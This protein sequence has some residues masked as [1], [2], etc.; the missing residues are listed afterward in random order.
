MQPRLRPL[1][2]AIPSPRSYFFR[3]FSP[4]SV[5][6]CSDLASASKKGNEKTSLR[7]GNADGKTETKK[8]AH[9]DETQKKNERKKSAGALSIR[10]ASPSLFRVL[11]PRSK[12]ATTRIKSES[13]SN[14]CVKSEIMSTKRRNRQ[15]KRIFFPSPAVVLLEERKQ[16]RKKSI[17]LSPS[18]PPLA[19]KNGPILPPR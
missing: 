1:R 3:L 14:R 6:S 16:R 18:L 2:A 11:K 9:R 17:A 4:I 8:A 15:A 13:C 7:R 19:K 10:N 12:H 5:D